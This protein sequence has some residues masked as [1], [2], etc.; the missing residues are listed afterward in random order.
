[1]NMFRY[2]LKVTGDLDMNMTV[3]DLNDA[4]CTYMMWIS[5]CQFKIEHVAL[6][7]MKNLEDSKSGNQLGQ[8]R[9]FLKLIKFDE[10]LTSRKEKQ[11][12]NN[13]LCVMCLN[14]EKDEV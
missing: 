6:G 2:L 8:Q 9:H 11:S 14:P 4:Q 1:M 13:A 12:R 7:M 3:S 10:N 5:S